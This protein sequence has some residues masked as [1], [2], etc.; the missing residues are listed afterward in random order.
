[1]ETHNIRFEYRIIKLD[2]GLFNYIPQVR[3]SR[4]FEPFPDWRTREESF[5][6]EFSAIKFIERLKTIDMKFWIEK[7]S[8]PKPKTPPKVVY[9]DTLT[10][11]RD[12]VMRNIKENK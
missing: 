7:M 2:N 4:N 10:V 1:M 3:C 6:F 9:S 12:E 8:P 5:M 11:D